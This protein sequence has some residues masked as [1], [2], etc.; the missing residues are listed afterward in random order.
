MIQLRD[1]NSTGEQNLK[2]LETKLTVDQIVKRL[3]NYRG[4]FAEM[5]HREFSPVD[6]KSREVKSK[7]TPRLAGVLLL[8]YLKKGK[9]HFL[10]TQRQDYDGT[11][12]NQISLPGGKKEDEDQD[13]LETALRETFEEVGSVHSRQSV[14]SL[15]QVYIP[16]SN[17]LVSPF[18]KVEFD[19]VAFKR[20]QYEVRSLIEI[21]LSDLLEASP[22]SKDLAELS[23][24]RKYKTQVQ[25]FDFNSKIVWGATALMIN[26]LRLVL[27]Q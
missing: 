9:P 27:L 14:F 11:H 13:M 7:V 4:E 10:L 3:Q 24:V 6:L 22:T 26:E 18:V 20:D 5:A 25:V 8:I 12:A 21:P 15:G 17:F 19:E 1:V 16:P 23:S 2:S